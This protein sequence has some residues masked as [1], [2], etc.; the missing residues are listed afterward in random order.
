MACDIPD[1]A[2]CLRSEGWKQGCL[3]SSNIA[4]QIIATTID[5]YR[6]DTDTSSD[7]WLVVLT[8]DCDLVRVVKDEPFVELLAIQK[9]PKK[10]ENPM[11]GQSARY[12]HLVLD[13]EHETHWFD[14]NIH[15]RFR[16]DKESLCQLDCDTTLF[17]EEKELRLLRQWLARR[18]TR[19]AFP[20]HFET[21]L[22][23][24]K[25][26]VKSLFKSQEAKLISTVYIAI[27]NEDA[28]ADQDYF[29]HV[30][31]T[32]LAEDL[33]DA[34]KREQIDDFEERFISVFNGRPHICF[35]LKNPDD[36][37]SYDVRVLPE[38]DVTL[39]ILRKYKRFDA[40]YRSVDDAVSP[41]EG[42][43]AS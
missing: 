33:G 15:D 26:K 19:A 6:Q 37:E 35:A 34:D 38:E 17:F 14:C 29:I 11:R 8:Q 2:D 24:T 7:V 31:L 39:S 43:D 12:L 36:A 23:S 3:I 20:D 28:G 13:V 9:L 21:Y 22:A 1:A 4:E 18:Y 25:G 40:D 30:I 16:I 5:F 42:V 10:P 41:P 32:A 27:D